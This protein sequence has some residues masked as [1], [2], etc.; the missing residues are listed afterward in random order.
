MIHWW[1]A[2]MDAECS[3]VQAHFRHCQG[4]ATPALR[5]WWNPEPPLADLHQIRVGD[6]TFRR[7][8][9]HA[10]NCAAA[11]WLVPEPGAAKASMPHKSQH[12][13]FLLPMKGHGLLHPTLPKKQAQSPAARIVCLLKQSVSQQRG[14]AN[15]LWLLD[16]DSWLILIEPLL[17]L[18]LL[19]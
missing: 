9:H 3:G 4:G 6:V 10:F 5:S 8:T 17:L 14:D 7:H 16:D 2:K 19:L 1:S 18:W 12:W 15:S 11:E 13:S